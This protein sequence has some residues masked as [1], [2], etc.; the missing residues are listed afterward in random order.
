[1]IALLIAEGHP[2]HVVVHHGS[3]HDLG[4]PG[5]GL[6]AAVDLAFARDDYGPELRSWLV[7]RLGLTD[8]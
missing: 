5:G 4:N 1:A 8:R 2:V 6:E 3:R 7:K